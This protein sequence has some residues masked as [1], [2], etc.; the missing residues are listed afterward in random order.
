[1]GKKVVLEKVLEEMLKMSGGYS[2]D[3]Y[4]SQGKGEYILL[5]SLLSL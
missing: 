1:M 2:Y 4:D 5:V 3:F